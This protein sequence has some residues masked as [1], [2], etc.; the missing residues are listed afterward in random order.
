MM[1]RCL[2]CDASAQGYDFPSPSAL[3][4]TRCM[5]K[6]SDERH[7]AAIGTLGTKMAEAADKLLDDRPL[8]DQVHEATFSSPRGLHFIQDKYALRMLLRRAHRFMLDDSTSALIADFSKAVIPDLDGSRRLAVPPFPVTWFELNNKERLRRSAELGVKYAAPIP[9]K[10]DLE[11]GGVIE[12]CGWLLHPSI[13]P[14][15]HFATYFA[16][17]NFGPLALPMSYFWHTDTPGPEEFGPGHRD[18]DWIRQMQ[19]LCFGLTQQ[20]GLKRIDLGASDAYPY[21][22]PLHVPVLDIKLIGRDVMLMMVEA[23]GELRHIWGLLVALGAGQL[24]VEADTSGRVQHTGP[25]RKA[26]DK[27]LLPLEHKV[28]HLHLSKRVTPEKAVLRAISHHK[29]REHEVRSH[30]RTYR[31]EDGTVRRRTLI[32]DHKRG[33]IRLGR[34]EKTY[35]VER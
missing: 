32:K 19:W 7:P 24:G 10:S 5:D 18:D 35:R 20:H 11:Y 3:T 30:F 21:P 34:V 27:P 25:I 6:I 29:N 4:C 14:P 15:G 2:H 13:E 33:D 23:A 28:L 26:G 9:V 17:G 22:S 12:R 1:R 31:N 8:I 16:A